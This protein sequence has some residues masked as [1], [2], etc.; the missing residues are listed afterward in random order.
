MIDTI[1]FDLDGTLV[2]ASRDIASATNYVLEKI[3]RPGLPVE[4]IAGYIGG[5][6]EALWRKVLGGE[7]DALLPTV[8]PQFLE[9]YTAHACD[10]TVLYPG[11][12]DVLLVL[13]KARFKLAI[14]TQKVEAISF[15]IMDKLRI[16]SFF[17]VII[18]PES[19]THRK[20]HPESVLVILERLGCRAEQAWMVGDTPA[21]ILAG[22]AAGVQTVGV[23]YGYGLKEEIVS[24]GP[25]F[26]IDRLVELIDLLQPISRLTDQAGG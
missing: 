20:P 19:I 14:A 21:D 25:N 15:E 17:P 7:A 1:I 22:K 9:R 5:G 2:D 3:G 8:L 24:A 11:A 18:G 4:T 6:A 23:T 26:V 12:L 10:E 13:E 16:R